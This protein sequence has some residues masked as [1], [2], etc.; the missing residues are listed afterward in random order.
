MKRLIAASAA[1][2][3]TLA[4]SAQNLQELYRS[5][6]YPEV[7]ARLDG[8][9]DADAQALRALCALKMQLPGAR[10]MASAFTER[11]PEHIQTPQVRL[12]WALGLFDAQ[13]YEGALA[14]LG[15]LSQSDILPSQVAEFNY[16]MGYCAYQANEWD[17]ARS[18]LERA[19][20]LP[21]SDYTAPS[22]YT[23][24]YVSYAQKSFGEAAQWFE[25]AAEDHRFSL[26]ANY[27]VLECRFNLKDYDYVVRYGEDLFNKVPEDRQPHMARI[28]SES[29]LVL[30][31]IEKARTYYEKNLRNKSNLNRS[32][33]FYA[34]EVNYLIQNWEGAVENYERMTHRTDSLGQI[35][36]Y[37]LGYS[38][39]Q[40]KNKVAAMD[41]FREASCL[42]F[43]P[44]IQEDALYNY[45]KL[46]FDLNRDT[47]PFQ[48]Y[49]ERYGSHRK[50]DQI[51]SYM[52]MVAL[53][54]HDYEA[55]V[56]AYDHIDELDPRMR[57]NYMK[58]YLLR[59]KELMENGSW[60]TA[61]PH[62]KAASYYSSRRDGFNQLSRYWLAEA[63]YRDGK[64]AEA[65]AILGD[66]YNLSA[67][68]G[69]PEGALINY[70]MAY[71]Y[72][73]EADYSRALKWFQNYLET[74]HPVQGSDA[75]TRVADCYFF[76][77][78]YTTA[79]A[80]Y[81]K[82]MN[83]YPDANNLYPRFRAGLASGLLEDNARKAHF[84]EPAKTASP[85][86]P[87]YGESL[88]ELGRAYVALNDEEDAIR[89]FRTLRT[90]TSDPNLATRALLELGMVSR[91]SGRGDEAI[92]YY[93]EVVAQ[94]GEYAE[95][96]LL[97]IEAIYRTRQDPEAYLDYVN[98]LGSQA[99]RS[100]AQKEEVYF[101]SAEQIYLSGDYS[102]ALATLQAYLEKYPQP[103]FG[104]KARF[105][106]AE[107]YRFTGAPEQAVDAYDAALQEGLEGALAEGAILQYASLQY[108]L[109]SY[110]KAY[111]AYLRLKESAVLEANRRTAGIG[112][113][114][115]AYRA[116]EWADAIGDAT[117]VLQNAS[118]DEALAREAR[119]LR[120]KS[121]LSSSRR[122]EAFAELK[123]LSEQPST[124][125]GA[126][127]AY[128]LIQD[129]YDRARFDGIQDAVYDFSGKAG[130]QNY[131][132][133]KAFIVL[134]DTFAEQGNLAQ[135]RA[136]FQSIKNGYTS[137]G[138]QDEVLDQVEL[139]LNKLN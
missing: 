113:M 2:L 3:L 25:L 93:K 45:A 111:G 126:E 46:A 86:A 40:L 66:L 59:A 121:Y 77:G 83:D 115:S 91:N 32:D 108:Q 8:R 88:Y 37:Q 14:Q 31:D 110:A 112:L 127:A 82:Q 16:K 84:L 133:A 80:A 49:L 21:Y 67:L 62:L 81:E 106:L 50:G 72:F 47:A 11:F 138:A 103:A 24:G 137:T 10:E 6:Q 139:R 28:M 107:C 42:T 27:Y 128:L 20:T 38:Y 135:A 58:A 90:S 95:D 85:Q 17:R 15:R 44:D 125:E 79:V 7:M 99:K 105:Y 5:G 116:R 19:R 71:T 56:E 43:T 78:D 23:L 33:Y 22:Y 101:S 73:K 34:G 129:Q 75:M 117:A 87:Y 52:A 118:D 94:G 9:S 123:I 69:R 26:L 104:A 54:N 13:D 64:Y 68:S 1:L 97:A 89:A 30:G 98:S 51:Y 109:G 122:E 60:R 119:Y 131:W 136:T 4:A 55:A 120:A 29:Y 76:S 102:K 48:D 63:Y 92:G 53:Q 132:L 114:R 12:E 100:E 61:V 39:I 74:D 96:A 65:R 36:A 57:S 134:G 18:Y 130:G 41:A 70:Q 35:A 124:D